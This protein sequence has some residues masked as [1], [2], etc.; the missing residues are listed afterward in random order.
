MT[1]SIGLYCTG[2]T[3]FLTLLA[4]YTDIHPPDVTD[5]LYER[6]SL[7][8]T[9]GM[10]SS[11]FAVPRPLLPM[12]FQATKAR[13]QKWVDSFLRQLGVPAKDYVRI[14]GRIEKLLAT[15]NL[16]V[17]EIK[18]ALALRNVWGSEGLRRIINRML[19][20]GRLVRGRARGGWRSDLTEYALFENWLPEVRL[21]SV[22]V[23]EAR[24]HLAQRY[25]EAYG[26]ATAADFHWW[27]GLTK[28]EAD[29]ALAGVNGVLASVMIDELA[30]EYYLLKKD[31]DELR[32]TSAKTP[33]GVSLLPV[34]DAYMMAYRERER[35]LSP[36]L[37][38]RVYD[39]SGNSTL[40][41]LLAGRVAGVW[42]MQEERKALTLKIALFEPADRRVWRAVRRAA[43]ELARELSAGD[44][45]TV[46]I[47]RC[48]PSLPITGH[49]QF[50][51]PLRDNTGELDD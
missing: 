29:T 31:A 39:K 19:V 6:R 36:A 1:A 20:E 40:T 35:Y 10:R 21:D 7:V 3:T 12:V 37:H 27:S 44:L 45:K 32:S 30:G 43:E 18:Q 23:D 14:A 42:D 49:S 16:T 5:A 50:Y 41:V 2:T 51:S 22:T 48:P 25:F 9:W 8:R 15:R 17:T 24:V 38:N 33:P 47:L 26:P 34:W 28:A 46:R 4:R 11:V 13:A